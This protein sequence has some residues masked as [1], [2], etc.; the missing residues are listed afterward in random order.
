[1]SSVGT[2]INPKVWPSFVLL[3]RSSLLSHIIDDDDASDKHREHQRQ[4]ECHL[5]T[6]TKLEKPSTEAMIHV[7][8]M[9]LAF[10]SCAYMRQAPS[11]AVGVQG[12]ARQGKAKASTTTMPGEP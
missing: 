2:I 5:L 9:L 6:R 12:E 1:M 3:N 4:S 7:V 10:S 8:R 11:E